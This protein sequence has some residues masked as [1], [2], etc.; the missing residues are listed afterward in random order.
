MDIDKWYPS[1]IPAPSAK[2]IRDMFEESKLEFGGIN[3]DK[4]SRYLGE[5]LTEDEIKQEEMEEIVYIKIKKVKKVKV[6]N[7]K[8]I[9]KKQAR[10]YATNVNR[11][12]K[13]KGKP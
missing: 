10:K 6:K 9:G 8:T 13:E 4:V 12:Q 2:G 11:K 1:T 5:Y 3:Y 7:S